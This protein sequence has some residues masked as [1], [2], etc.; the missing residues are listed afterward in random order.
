MHNPNHRNAPA[1]SGLAGL[2]R[3]LHGSAI[4]ETDW[5]ELLRVLGP[6]AFCFAYPSKCDGGVPMVGS[7]GSGTGGG[8]Q[9]PQGGGQT[10]QAGFSLSSLAPYLI[11]AAGGGL[12]FSMIKNKK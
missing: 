7:G 3:S 4:G 10:N 12:M 6:T 11:L 5:P 9:P 2:D 1:A 8:Y